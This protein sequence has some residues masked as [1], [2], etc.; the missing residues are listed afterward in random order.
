MNP[1]PLNP[2]AQN[3]FVA[4]SHEEVRSHGRAPRPLGEMV[5]IEALHEP[6]SDLGP[7]FGGLGYTG[8]CR[9]F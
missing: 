3:L 4:Q 2:K 7:F 9:G 1:K 5:L 6:P 8:V